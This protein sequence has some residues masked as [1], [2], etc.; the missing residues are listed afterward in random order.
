MIRDTLLAVLYPIY[1]NLIQVAYW[2][3][4]ALLP[5]IKLCRAPF[6]YVASVLIS[7][8]MLLYETISRLYSASDQIR[9]NANHRNFS[10]KKFVLLLAVWMAFLV[11]WLIATSLTTVPWWFCLVIF[12][13][14]YF[15][16][17]SQITDHLVKKY[18][19]DLDVAACLLCWVGMIMFLICLLPFILGWPF[20][21]P[22]AWL[23]V[24]AIAAGL[25][26]I[27]IGVFRKAYPAS[28]KS[29]NRSLKEIVP[30]LILWIWD[31]LWRL[32]DGLPWISKVLWP[33]IRYGLVC[34]LFAIVALVVFI[35]VV[36]VK[37]VQAVRG[38]PEDIRRKS[39]LLPSSLWVFIPFV[40]ILPMGADYT[41]QYDYIYVLAALFG[42][43]LTHAYVK[44]LLTKEYRFSEDSAGAVMFLLGVVIMNLGWIVLWIQKDMALMA[45]VWYGNGIWLAG[46]ISVAADLILEIKQAVVF[47]ARLAPRSLSM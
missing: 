1:S 17:R 22:T 18:E 38:L 45:V 25:V 7:A 13:S 37:I 39:S 35:I 34:A 40:F 42:M 31:G 46:L 41:R 3:W 36:S 23:G 16:A 43:V 32:A 27:F 6:L 11:V 14:G 2:S 9:E 10:P 26:T 29:L 20:Y 30:E 8:F 19:F 4:K 21:R 5:L 47:S 24:G 12:L 33:W 28:M 44:L 15:A